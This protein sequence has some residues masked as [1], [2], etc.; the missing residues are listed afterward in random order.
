MFTSAV[1]GKRPLIWVLFACFTALAPAG[2]FAADSAV[3]IMYHRFGE[4]RY[5]STNTTIEQFRAHLRELKDGNYV[6]KPVPEILAAIR[7]GTELPDKTVGIT[8][9]DAFSSVYK[10]GWP[11]LRRAGLPF[12]LFVAT[13]PLDRKTSGYMSWDQLRELHKAGVTIGSQTATHLHMPHATDQQNKVDLESSNTR[14]KAELGFIPKIIAYPYGE[15]SL[16]VGKVT[17]AAGFEVGFGQHS[18]A[19]YKKSDFLYLPRFAFNEAFGDIQRFR[20]AVRALPFKVSDLTPADPYLK[21]KQNPPPFGFTVDGEAVKRLSRIACYATRQ[22]K[23]NVERLGER[24]IEVRAPKA[25]SPGRTRMNCTLLEKNGRWRWLGMQYLV[26][27]P[28]RN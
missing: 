22:G 24:R 11:M 5:P 9:D 13:E 18:G 1:R 19:I 12:T 21:N 6:V 2:V 16:A 4:S 26:P 27:K 8:I 10:I 28:K 3:V 23:V 20:L 15:Y 17:R 25:F 7:S 14:F